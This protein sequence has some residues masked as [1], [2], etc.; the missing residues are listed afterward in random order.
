MVLRFN[1][2]AGT[3]RF[4]FSISTR[5]ARDEAVWQTDDVVCSGERWVEE[6]EETLP[7]VSLLGT[8]QV[9]L[10]GDRF[11]QRVIVF[12]VKAQGM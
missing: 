8:Q 12:W 1:A 10:G 3:S 11:G 6:V 2:A 7:E 5:E 4:V 9:T